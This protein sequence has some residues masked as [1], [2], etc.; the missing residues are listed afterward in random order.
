MVHNLVG[1]NLNAARFAV[2]ENGVDH[3]RR[4]T[5]PISVSLI[6]LLTFSH[7]IDPLHKR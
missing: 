7:D 4:E 3:M 2:S 6:F 1:L 5:C